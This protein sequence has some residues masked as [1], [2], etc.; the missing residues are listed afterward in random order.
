MSTQWTL[1]WGTAEAEAKVPSAENPPLSKVTAFTSGV[2]Q[3]IALLTSP[4]ARDSAFLMS[5]CSVH[6]SSL[7][8]NGLQESQMATVMHNDSHFFQTFVSSLYDLRG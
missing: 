7:F 8:A 1:R 3:T 2:G 6:S 5:A 4:F